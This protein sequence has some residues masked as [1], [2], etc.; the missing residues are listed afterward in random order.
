M[1]NASHIRV[2]TASEDL[3]ERH[4]IAFNLSFALFAAGNVALLGL[5]VAMA[6]IH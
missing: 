5:A 1:R 6:G 2:A 4:W 3:G